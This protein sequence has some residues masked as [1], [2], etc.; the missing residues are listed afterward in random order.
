MSSTVALKAVFPIRWFTRSYE[1]KC[2]A[3]PPCMMET[4]IIFPAKKYLSSL[5]AV[6]VGKEISLHNY[7][8]HELKKIQMKMFKNFKPLKYNLCCYWICLLN[9]TQ[10]T[11]FREF[12]RRWGDFWGESWEL[13]DILVLAH[14]H[15]TLLQGNPHLLWTWRRCHCILSMCTVKIHGQL[16]PTHQI[17]KCWTG[18]HPCGQLQVPNLQLIQLPGH[19]WVLRKKEVSNFLYT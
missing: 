11:V 12:H 19:L 1:R 6:R 7:H 15:P 10:D 3:G 14:L 16:H 2:C 13:L 5:T 4:T 9:C 18:W 17:L 8:P